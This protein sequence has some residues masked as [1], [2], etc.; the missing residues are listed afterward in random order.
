MLQAILHRTGVGP[1][2]FVEIGAGS[3]REANFV[4]LADVLGFRGVAIEAEPASYESLAAK[5]ATNPRVT[6]LNE[7]VGEDNV[8]ALVAA[9]VDGEDLSVLSI[10]IDGTDWWVWRALTCVRPRVVV[11]EYNAALGQERA[12]TVP[13]DHPAPWDATDY[14]GASLPALELLAAARGYRLVHTD[15]SGVNAFFVRED[16]GAGL[17][18][19]DE[20]LRRAPNFALAGLRHQPDPARRP[21]VEVTAE[22][23]R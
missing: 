14:H 17:P 13:R 21:Y 2:A 12:L 16:A 9:H 20:V 3:G 18:A 5:Y 23:C 1:G 6:T 10:D 22:L 15:L 19:A 11:I 4:F 8:D 7:R